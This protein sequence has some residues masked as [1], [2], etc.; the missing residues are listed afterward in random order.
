MFLL[1]VV[2]EPS[3]GLANLV[4]DPKANSP[5]AIARYVARATGSN[6]Q[7][8]GKQDGRSTTDLALHVRFARSPSSQVL[9]GLK[10]RHRTELG[11]FEGLS[12]SVQ[13]EKAQQPRDVLAQ[14]EPFGPEFLPVVALKAADDRVA[15]GLRRIALRTFVRGMHPERACS[16]VRL[17]AAACT[18]GRVRRPVGRLDNFD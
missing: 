2:S 10:A 16:R 12:I 4:H 13:G 6:I 18:T 9:E 5:N 11:G 15:R 1:I 7:A 14:L 3:A 17:G 8:I